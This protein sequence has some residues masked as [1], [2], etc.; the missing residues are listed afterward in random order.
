MYR[1]VELLFFT[2]GSAY[3]VSGSYPPD[4]LRPPHQQSQQTHQHETI[5]SRHDV[6]NDNQ[7]DDNS[8]KYETTNP[9][10]AADHKEYG[11]PRVVYDPSKSTNI[12]TNLSAGTREY[13]LMPDER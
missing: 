12:N 3:F 6:G 11:K 7:D 1:F 2:V 4:A 13:Q 5:R 8:A 10:Q 9:I